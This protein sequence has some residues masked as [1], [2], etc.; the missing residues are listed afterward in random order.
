VGLIVVPEPSCAP[1][2][3]VRYDKAGDVVTVIDAASGQAR[4]KVVKSAKGK[5]EKLAP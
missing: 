5:A 3:R 2:R 1:C 4:A